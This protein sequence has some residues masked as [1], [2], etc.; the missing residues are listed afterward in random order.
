MPRKTSPTLTDAELRLMDVLWDRGPSTVGE[1][2]DALPA[3]VAL[4]YSTVLTTMRILEDKGYLKHAKAGRAFVY[5]PVMGRPE[6]S[7]NAVRY[8]LSRFFANQPDQLVMSILNDEELSEGELRRLRKLMEKEG[9]S[10]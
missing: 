1:V 9:E 8:V 7:R 3:E 6:V 10:K 4:A 2:V 5:E